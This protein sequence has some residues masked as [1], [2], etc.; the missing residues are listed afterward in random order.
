MSE[1]HDGSDPEPVIISVGA[2]SRTVVLCAPCRDAAARLGLIERRAMDR[3][4]PE[5]NLID[6]SDG[7]RNER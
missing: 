5:G 6:E 7:G 4:R 1:Q 2:H 3:N